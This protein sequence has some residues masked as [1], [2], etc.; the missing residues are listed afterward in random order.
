MTAYVIA[1]MI[2][3]QHLVSY[4]MAVVGSHTAVGQGAEAELPPMEELS[5][6]AARQFLSVKSK[7][8]FSLS[9]AARGFAAA[10]KAKGAR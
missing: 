9:T 5:A 3:P 7:E 1:Y 6:A 2:V 4:M 10:G 8:V